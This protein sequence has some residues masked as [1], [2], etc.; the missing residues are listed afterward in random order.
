MV[1]ASHSPESCGAHSHLREQ[2]ATSQRKL[3]EVATAKGVTIQG[4]WVDAPG[5]TAF[6]LVDA[7]NAH[8]IMEAIM[9][10]GMM[11]LWTCA[12]HPVILGANALQA[13]PQ[14]Q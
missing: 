13:I 5:H 11:A 3:A 8:V 1:V 4:Q 12:I 2:H 14:V 10:S 7:P 6:S 9:D